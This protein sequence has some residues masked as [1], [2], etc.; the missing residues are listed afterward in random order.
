M[1]GNISKTNYSKISINSHPRSGTNFLRLNLSYLL[2]VELD[3]IGKHN[4]SW[5]TMDKRNLQVVVLRNPVDTIFSAFAHGERA[6]GTTETIEKSL[7]SQVGIY[8]N[9]LEAYRRFLENISLYDF[10]D[11]DQAI[12]DIALKFIDKMPN[13]FVAKQPK[14]TEEFCPSMVNSDFYKRLLSEKL[15]YRIF[16]PAID[17]YEELLLEI[18]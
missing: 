7:I 16:D 10:R 11:I 2:G 13:N 5:L 3:F 1:L 4:P 14:E 12:V 18:K 6:N 15:D 17:I 8:V 9:H